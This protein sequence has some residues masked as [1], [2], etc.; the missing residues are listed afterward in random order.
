M[1]KF[2]PLVWAIV[3]GYPISPH[4]SLFFRRFCLYRMVYILQ[5]CPGCMISSG[6]HQEIIARESPFMKLGHLLLDHP[7]FTSNFSHSI[8]FFPMGIFFLYNLIIP[9][10]QPW[11][12]LSNQFVLRQPLKFTC[13]V[14]K[15]LDYDVGISINQWNC[16]TCIECAKKLSFV[17][18]KVSLVPDIRG[19]NL[20][21]GTFLWDK[22]IFFGTPDVNLFILLTLK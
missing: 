9:T 2:G 3:G 17:P 19:T 21:Y 5:R 18:K 1:H 7:T 11:I 6:L 15:S 8:R 4:L 12:I 22:G 16:I 14:S 20:L 13:D 10:I